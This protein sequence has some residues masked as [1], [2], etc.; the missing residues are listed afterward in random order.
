MVGGTLAPAAHIDR[1]ADHALADQERWP[2]ARVLANG[3]SRATSRHR[4]SSP[5]VAPS[6]CGLR[7]LPGDHALT[8]APGAASADADAPCDEDCNRAA[9]RLQCRGPIL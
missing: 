3:N 4:L 6:R 7:R 9:A 5:A 1:L 2:G 8:A